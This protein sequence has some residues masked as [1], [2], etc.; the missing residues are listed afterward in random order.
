MIMKL[1]II[2]KLM[3]NL[4]LLW[5]TCGIYKQFLSE[6]HLYS[7]CFQS[8]CEKMVILSAD[9]FKVI[10][11]LHCALW[12]YEGSALWL[13]SAMS[14]HACS[15]WRLNWIELT[16]FNDQLGCVRWVEV[17]LYYVWQ[18]GVGVLYL[19]LSL[20]PPPK[21]VY[22]G[23]RT[24]QLV[25]LFWRWTSSMPS[26]SQHPYWWGSLDVHLWL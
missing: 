24:T 2:S 20:F 15:G 12:D 14:N 13:H 4:M 19:Y 26:R 10:S 17:K 6:N 1:C 23:R 18:A 5:M 9:T 8:R 21:N 7:T 3:Y 22:S 16:I 25:S 11:P